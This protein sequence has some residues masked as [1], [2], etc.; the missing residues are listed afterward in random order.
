MD[1][2][3]EP[4]ALGAPVT[5]QDK[6]I[7]NLPLPAQEKLRG[8]EGFHPLAQALIQQYVKTI[9]SLQEVIAGRIP[10]HLPQDLRWREKKDRIIR[11]FSTRQLAW[12][13]EL[14]PEGG[15]SV[16]SGRR[17]TNFFFESDETF[18]QRLVRTVAE[19]KGIERTIKRDSIDLQQG[20]REPT[21]TSTETI[22]Q[23][24]IF[25][26]SHKRPD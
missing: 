14:T 18:K 24:P 11:F 22:R 2:E 16:I 15:V 20:T 9:E 26:W 21:T 7:V 13:A 19:T 17:E 25:R 3:I 4:V 12:K 6:A 10:Q 5:S 1:A 23:E 8:Q